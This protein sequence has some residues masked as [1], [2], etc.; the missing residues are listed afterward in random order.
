[1]N[2]HEPSPWGESKGLA[3]AILR[4]RAERRKWLT[5]MV[6]GLVVMIAIGIWVLD[7]WI[8]ESVWRAIFWWGGCALGT[9]VV[10]IFVAYDALVVT[11]EERDR[12]R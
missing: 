10:L 7:T 6:L 11:G 12:R 9:F 3:Q 5:R 1:M 2:D 8:W 4:N